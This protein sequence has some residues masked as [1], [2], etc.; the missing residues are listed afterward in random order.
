LAGDWF[1]RD[2]VL[3]H[4]VGLYGGIFRRAVLLHTRTRI[5]I[6]E[7]VCDKIAAS[8][9]KGIWV[10][11]KRASYR[12][13]PGRPPKE[14]QFKPGRSGNPKGAKRK[15]PSIAPDLKGVVR[16]CAQ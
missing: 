2:C 7:R 1:D 10:A 12:V 15:S 11:S 3:S 8:K 5:V 6:G 13:G 4:G 14:F 9:R 16:T